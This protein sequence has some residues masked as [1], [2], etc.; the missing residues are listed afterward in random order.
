MFGVTMDS[1]TEGD[2]SFAVPVGNSTTADPRTAGNSEPAPAL[3]ALPAAP[4]PFKPASALEIKDL[5][6]YDEASCRIPYPD[7]EAKDL[8]IEGS[9]LLRVEIDERGKVHGVRV[10]RGV[11]H[12]LDET[13]I[14]A[15]R[16]KCRFSPARNSAG[17]AV[18]FTI[19]YTYTWEID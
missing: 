13:A 9:T 8:G 7:G 4:P 11:G 6:S 3:P 1:T 19:T 12:G 18:P 2:S 15:I 14:R 16:Y 5:P 10:L 17:L